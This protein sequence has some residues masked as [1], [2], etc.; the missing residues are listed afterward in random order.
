[1]KEKCTPIVLMDGDMV[2]CPLSLEIL[3]PLR[4]IRGRGNWAL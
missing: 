1:M 3:Y 4:L 2:G